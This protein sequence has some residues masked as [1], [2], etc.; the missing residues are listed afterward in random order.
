MGLFVITARASPTMKQ[1][2]ETK[3]AAAA[4]RA[5]RPP[6]AVAISAIRIAKGITRAG[7]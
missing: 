3:T 7:R 6:I 1:R 5:W 2:P 4:S